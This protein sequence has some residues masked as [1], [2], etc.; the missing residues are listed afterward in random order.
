MHGS[1]SFI[2]KILSYG[3]YSQCFLGKKK[4]GHFP[5]PP[6]TAVPG[7]TAHSA[8]LAGRAALADN[9]LPS[10]T[11]AVRKPS[12]KVF[13][14]QT[15]DPQLILIPGISESVLDKKS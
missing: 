1:S 6:F 13:L 12:N 7:F 4:S 2:I 15:L 11:I 10:R 8:P 14:D 9:R 3:K 5:R